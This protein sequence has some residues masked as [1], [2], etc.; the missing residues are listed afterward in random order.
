[1]G[2]SESARHVYRLGVRAWRQDGRVTLGAMNTYTE[3]T[4]PE[5]EENEKK[6]IK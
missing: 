2:G 6:E 5:K 1:M 4:L 3:E